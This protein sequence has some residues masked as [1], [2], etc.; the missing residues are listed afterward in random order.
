MRSDVINSNSGSFNYDKKRI[1]HIDN[2]Q[3]VA[4]TLLAS[5]SGTLFLV[6]MSTVDNNVAITLP[7]AAGSEGVHYDFCFT[8][9]SD[10]DADFSITTGADATD[11]FG[12]VVC[13]GANST[14][15]DF[16]GL[17]KITIDGS[18][19]QTSEGLRMTF[20]CDG[21]NWHLSGYVSTVIGTAHLVESA[22][23]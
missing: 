8:V 3:A 16:D 20:L 2:S 12:Y 9:N 15:D 4:R 22:T 14:V 5:E 11:I 17:S 10:D 19:S 1:Q 21:V 6:D 7:T 13:G 23:A 18:A